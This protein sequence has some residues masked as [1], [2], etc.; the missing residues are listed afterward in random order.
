MFLLK[1]NTF[2]VAAIFF[3][4]LAEQSLEIIPVPASRLP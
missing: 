1:K 2:R 3:N 4:A